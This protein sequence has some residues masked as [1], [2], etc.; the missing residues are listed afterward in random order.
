MLT[1][2]WIYCGQMWSHV[3]VSLKG[4]SL[5]KC[6]IKQKEQS[7]QD[8]Y[9]NMHIK[10]CTDT[11]LHISFCKLS[12]SLSQPVKG[13]QPCEPLI[14]NP[15]IQSINYNQQRHKAIIATKEFQSSPD[16]KM[17]SQTLKSFLSNAHFS[18]SV[19]PQ[20]MLRKKKKRAKLVYSIYG[21]LLDYCPEDR[22]VRNKMGLTTGCHSRLKPCYIIC[23][24][25]R[26]KFWI[27]LSLCL[28][29]SMAEASEG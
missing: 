22:K 25:G 21:L 18:R 3:S 1:T 20:K 13:S 15:K 5:L 4:I 11:Q 2:E 29:Y 7:I 16:A 14:I 9:Q 26:R 27:F 12:E 6:V 24:S 17:V 28:N 23:V 8:H 19:F 10:M